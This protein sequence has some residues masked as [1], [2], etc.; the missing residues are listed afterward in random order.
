MHLPTGDI[1]VLLVGMRDPRMHRCVARSIAMLT[2]DFM[3]FVVSE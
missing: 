1:L 3:K 2:H